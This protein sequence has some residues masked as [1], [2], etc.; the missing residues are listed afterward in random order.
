MH[1]AVVFLQS[2]MYRLLLISIFI[3]ILCSSCE[4]EECV[5]CNLNPKIKIDF[6]AAVS[7][8]WTDSVFTEVKSRIQLLADSL[9]GDLTEE[10]VEAIE[11]ELQT[12]R[13]DSIS[14]GED[15]NLFRSGQARIDEVLAPGSVDFEL[16]GDTIINEYALP[17]NM[18]SD[19]T[20]FY[21]SYHNIK[22]TLQIYY[23]R[24]IFQ[25]LDGF[26][27]LIRDIGY[28]RE[29]TTFDSVSVICQNQTCSHDRTTIIV[30]F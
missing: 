8:E 11:I 29:V 25:N 30:Y 17:V 15:Y 24:E 21:F 19:T 23:H 10:Q 2:S 26:R 12:L 22:D 20:T 1:P 7:L 27:M 6:E 9:N 18:Q 13:A 5:G 16:L 3:F 4:E 28:N 14:L